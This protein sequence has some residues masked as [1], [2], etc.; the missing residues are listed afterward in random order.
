[1]TDTA[2]QAYSGKAQVAFCRQLGDDW[3]PLAMCLEIP[4]R[5]CDRFAKGRECHAILHWL[6]QRNR[7]KELPG[8][9]EYIGRPELALIFQPPTLLVVAAQHWQKGSPYPGLMPFTADY[10][11]V[12]FGCDRDTAA[13]LERLEFVTAQSGPGHCP[14][15]GG[16]PIR[17]R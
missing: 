8:T 11:P 13:L 1:M 17:R 12:F 15:P 4:D 14:Y 2:D 7:L 3:L 9:L 16:C 6:R 5:D 10:A